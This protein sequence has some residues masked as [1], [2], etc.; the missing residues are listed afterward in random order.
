MTIA[1][2]TAPTAKVASDRTD[3]DSAD[4]LDSFARMYDDHAVRVFSLA[5]RIVRD[6]GAAED[7]VQEVF[8][9]AWTQ[10]RRYDQARGPLAC[11]VPH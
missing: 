7:V 9:Q 1:L 10:R 2:Q 3:F 8:L 4:D 5:M 11:A 6:V